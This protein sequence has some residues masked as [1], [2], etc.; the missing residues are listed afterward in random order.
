[1]LQIWS[2]Y[3][4]FFEPGA[5]GDHPDHPLHGDGAPDFREGGPVG[6]DPMKLI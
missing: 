1:M 2:H 3:A 5:D 4:Q 6:R